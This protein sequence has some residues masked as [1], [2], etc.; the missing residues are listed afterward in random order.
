MNGNPTPDV[1]LR[2]VIDTDLLVFFEQ[3]LDPDANQMAAFTRKDPS[4]RDAFMDH[5]T[6]IRGDNAVTIRTA[7]F[8]G[9][10]AGSV[11]SFVDDQLGEPEVTYWI[12]R[13]YWGKGI[14]T[15]ALSQFLGIQTRR[16]LYARAA[17]DNFASLRVLEKCGFTISGYER[18]FANARRTE[19]DEVVLKLG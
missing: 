5:W 8:D 17:K 2:P 6:R 1:T 12:G 3:Q 10:V 9:Q 14:A 4:D 15:A 16:P 19:I 11:A 18:G 7:L 13:E